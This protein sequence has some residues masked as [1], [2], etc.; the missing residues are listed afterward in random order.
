MEH[1]THTKLSAVA[2]LEHEVRDHTVKL[3]ALVVQDVASV[4]FALLTYIEARE[5]TCCSGKGAL[6]RF[7]DP[8]R[9]CFGASACLNAVQR[10]N[11]TEVASAGF[12][13]AMTTSSMESNRVQEECGHLHDDDQPMGHIDMSSQASTGSEHLINPHSAK[14]VPVQRHRK[15]SAVF[16][17]T[18]ANSCTPGLR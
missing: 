17:T 2:Y 10:S 1:V 14:R 7:S 11:G 3:G 4:A 15:F 12:H 18:S 6:P 9:G 8:V 5:N 16:G 13:T